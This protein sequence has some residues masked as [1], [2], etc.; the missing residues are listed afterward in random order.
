MAELI[1]P[2]G[3]IYSIDQDIGALRQQ[4]RR[5][6]TR[7]PS[8]IVHFTHQDFSKPLNLPPLDGVVMANALHFIRD[9]NSVLQLI[10][11]YLRPGSRLILVEYNVDRG[12]LWVPHPLSFPA[13]LK[14]AERN[15]FT[16]TRLLASRP[17]HFLKEIYSAL[18]IAP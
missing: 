7:F 12:N 16:E 3:I 17:S 13:W 2:N 18:S 1:G 9:K 4:E 8:Q 11:N 15:G 5:M 10:L 14:L 6:K